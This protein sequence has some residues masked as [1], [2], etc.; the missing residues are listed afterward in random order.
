MAAG[1]ITAGG[2]ALRIGLAIALVLA[3]L[4]PT[5]WN[6]LRWATES[7]EEFGP[8][9]LIAGLL[10]AAAWVLY[11]RAALQSIGFVGAALIAGIV[12]AFVWLA[13]DNGWLDPANTSALMWIAL[14]ALGLILGIGLSWSHFRRRITGQVDVEGDSPL[15]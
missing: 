9:K 5:R 15:S 8:E 13:I 10:L 11:V 1:S 12:G 7:I 6:Y 4:N 3:T 2:V 14:V